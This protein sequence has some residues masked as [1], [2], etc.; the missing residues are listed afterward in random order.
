MASFYEFRVAALEK[1]ASGEKN[2]QRSKEV[3]ARVAVSILNGV[4]GVSGLQP[5]N[6]GEMYFV[7]GMARDDKRKSSA[8]LSRHSPGGRRLRFAIRLVVSGERSND[9]SEG[10]ELEYCCDLQISVSS[11]GD[12]GKFIVGFLSKS[13]EFFERSA[14]EDVCNEIWTALQEQFSAVN[15]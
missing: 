6:C 7:D 14:N 13:M 8:E 4:L 11:T 10:K 1:I 12:D 15:G 3:L 5:G 9:G 2:R